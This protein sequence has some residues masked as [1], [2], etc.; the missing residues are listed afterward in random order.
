MREPFDKLPKEKR[1]LIIALSIEEFASKSYADASTDDIARRSGIA[2]GSLFY[3]FTN[4][5]GLYLYMLREVTSRVTKAI[6]DIITTSDDPRRA[7]T[8]RFYARISFCRENPMTVRFIQ[9]AAGEL[10]EEVF[11]EK[12]ALMN[13]YIDRYDSSSD[14]I[15]ENF[16]TRATL[17]TD[18]E[19]AS[20]VLN[21]F[22]TGISMYMLDRHKQMPEMTL[23][24]PELLR[25]K[26][27]RCF[28]ALFEGLC[29]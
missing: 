27:D 29:K 15:I 17:K 26:T 13:A 16:V 23:D 12:Q 4:K 10:S 14:E 21:M 24:D 20:D 2:K 25:E 9:R 8:D 11:V 7:L 6:G 5:K 22:W 18:K 1:E 3:Y 19:T 28:S